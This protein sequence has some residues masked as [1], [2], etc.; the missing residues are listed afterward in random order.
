MNKCSGFTWG[1]L[2]IKFMTECPFPSLQSSF[3]KLSSSLL[4]IKLI[5][6]FLAGFSAA[7]KS[8]PFSSE[9][10]CGDERRGKFK[11]RYLLNVLLK[12]TSHGR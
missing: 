8:A 3:I 2:T 9:V 10:E 6:K 11:G 4:T 5:K 7:K 1:L 12:H